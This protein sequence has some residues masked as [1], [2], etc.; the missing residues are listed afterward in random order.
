M[1]GKIPAKSALSKLDHVGVVVGDMEKAIARF[2]SLGFGPFAGP[3]GTRSTI[4]SFHGELRG[5]PADWKVNIS[6]AKMGDVLLELLQPLDGPSALKEFLESSGEGLHHL[7]FMVDDMR[8]ELP[9]MIG[10]GA[11]V[12]TSAI[13]EKGSGFAYLE[14]A[15]G[16]VL[17][18]LRQL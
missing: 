13:N 10:Q 7:G 4:I 3:N 16:G 18:E 12:L 11:R 9:V 6:K 15:A 8:S 5:K 1:D 17:M 2:S 14:S